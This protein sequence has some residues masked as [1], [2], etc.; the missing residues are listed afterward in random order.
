MQPLANRTDAGSAVSHVGDVDGDGAGDFLVG[1]PAAPDAG[2]QTQPGA[3]YLVFGSSGL[4]PSATQ[5]SL[6]TI[7]VRI[8]GSQD[9]ALTGI[10]VAA[11][12]DIDGDGFDDLLVGASGYDT[13]HADAGAVFVLYG[14]DTWRQAV[15]TGVGIDAAEVVFFGGSAG[16]R[17]GFSVD[18]AG[19]IDGDGYPELLMSA[20]GYDDSAQNAGAAFL[21]FRL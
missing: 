13:S 17:L 10:D 5:S 18:S 9:G 1:A 20:P 6:D 8:E 16:D 7:G 14:A 3:A 12:G 4:P 11:A 21:F 15:G 2:G 19:D